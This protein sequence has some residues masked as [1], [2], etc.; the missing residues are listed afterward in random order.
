MSKATVLAQVERPV[1][2]IKQ[3]HDLALDTA[4]IDS[5]GAIAVVPVFDELIAGDSLTLRWQGFYEG[6]PEDEWAS[7]LSLDDV[8]IKQPSL[9]FIPRNTVRFSDEADVS[10]ELVHSDGSE[11]NSLLQRFQMV[12]PGSARLAAPGI[13]G[14]D[15]S[16]PI[17]PG[18][19]PN[20]IVVQ[21]ADYPGMQS[22]DYVVLYADG[23]SADAHTVM[24]QKVEQVA[25]LEFP[26][27][28]EWLLANQG[29]EVTL[30]YQYARHGA[31]MSSGPLVVSVLKPL[32]LPPP[33]VE[34][35]TAEGGAGE[36]KGFLL[37][38]AA[39]SGVYVQVPE[40]VSLETGDQ[41]EVHWQGDPAGGQHIAT[42]PADISDVKRFLIPP[43]AVAANMGGEEKRFEVFYRFTPL[44][45]NLHDSRPFLL[46]IEPLP[47]SEY[48]TIQWG[49]ENRP[50]GPTLSLGDVPASGQE[51]F[52]RKW[53]FMAQGQLLTIEATG[54]AQAGGEARSIVRDAMPVTAAEALAQKISSGRVPRTFLSSL[55]MHTPMTL[56]ARVSFD[57]GKTLTYFTNNQNLSLVE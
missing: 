54:V 11:V 22:G 4:G 47:K 26:I 14:H 28:T 51:V 31:A 41:L 5:A 7:T 1:V 12:T 55:K 20:G 30:S 44:N 43:T 21:V 42:S 15:A 2:H 3:S 8:A 38:S 19:Y 29:A 53:S 48:P 32:D 33:T 27:G 17:D 45:D 35:A 6:D 34:R 9:V 56:M 36:H 24:S 50:I 39:R 46:R 40:S 10:F 37:A 25:A 16:Q 23:V 52:L 57:G 13:R 18:H 49:E